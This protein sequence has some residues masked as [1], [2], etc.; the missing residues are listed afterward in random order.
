MRE[1]DCILWKNPERDKIGVFF[2]Q[3]IE[4]ITNDLTNDNYRFKFINSNVAIN[5]LYTEI[6]D[7]EKNDHS[8]SRCYKKLEK[9]QELVKE[10][11]K[12]G[13]VTNGK[14][15]EE[16]ISIKTIRKD[17]IVEVKQ[18]VKHILHEMENTYLE[19]T[20]SVICDEILSKSDDF[21]TIEYLTHIFVSELVFMGYSARHIYF[22]N[23]GK[24]YPTHVVVRKCM[25]GKLDSGDVIK[26][27]KS[28]NHNN[29]CYNVR[30][31]S[32]S[33]NIERLSNLSEYG[34]SVK[35]E[36]TKARHIRSS[37]YE[38][39]LL[40]RIPGEAERSITI[41]DV[42]A[43]DQFA[44]FEKAEKQIDLFNS[45]LYLEDHNAN[46]IPLIREALVYN[47]DNKV[48][49]VEQGR[50]ETSKRPDRTLDDV[51][52]R[53]LLGRTMGEI[54]E[55]KVS[56]TKL[57]NIIKNHE[58]ALSNR[59][60]EM[61]F[62]ALWSTLEQFIPQDSGDESKHNKQNT[63]GRVEKYVI[64]CLM[65]NIASVMVNNI[66]NQFNRINGID[67]DH[68][69]N[70]GNEPKEIMEFGRA[71]IGNLKDQDLP[72]SPLLPETVNPL[73]RYRLD[74]LRGTFSSPKCYHDFLATKVSDLKYI[75]FL[76]YSERNAIMHK[77]TSST[78]LPPLLVFLH[79]IVDRTLREVIRELKK[80]GET[81]N[82]EE[83]FERIRETYDNKVT[84]LKELSQ[85]QFSADT[86]MDYL[87]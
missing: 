46:S 32:K 1:P 36:D 42:L 69:Q 60:P 75:L 57:K 51:S 76:S 85:D 86:L 8:K 65:K 35:I 63:F 28:F 19:K 83:A 11:I 24:F 22:K 48:Y 39:S 2:T 47:E 58:N 84:G 20:E 5:D 66:I 68:G 77:G 54:N 40:S 44:A 33:S 56:Y 79:S 70:I 59:F 82:V 73:L 81:K 9:W 87:L 50:D 10:D 62:V 14:S 25:K 26:F 6:V 34:I 29:S 45:I 12:F 13:L 38:G 31:F 41:F 55:E 71:L 43:K 4:E 64:P 21:N 17:Q 16:L 3:L 53:L 72:N 80:S 61:K 7:Y 37:E 23:R 27:I 78:Y 30:F 15:F 49:R 74:E 18:L 67:N 52:H